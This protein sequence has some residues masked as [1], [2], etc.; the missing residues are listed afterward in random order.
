MYIVNDFY[1]INAL[2]IPRKYIVSGQ[3]LTQE[4]KT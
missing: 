2:K 3:E 1:F 4:L